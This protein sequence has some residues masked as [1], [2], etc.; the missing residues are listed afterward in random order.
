MD[1][2]EKNSKDATLLR[3][4]IKDSLPL[5]D[6]EKKALAHCGFDLGTSILRDCR[7]NHFITTT[8]RVS[9]ALVF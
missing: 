2:I 6:E 3:D 9:G 7:S 4:L 8:V 5:I 1:V